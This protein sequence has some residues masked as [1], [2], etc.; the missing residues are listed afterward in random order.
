MQPYFKLKNYLV[1]MEWF[2]YLFT[3]LISSG[4]LLLKSLDNS[5]CIYGSPDSCKKEINACKREIQPDRWYMRIFFLFT[6]DNLKFWNY[7]SATSF[8]A[9]QLGNVLRAVPNCVVCRECSSEKKMDYLRA[10]DFLFQHCM[11]CTC[12]HRSRKL[13]IVFRYR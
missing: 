2:F 5:L 10:A 7:K 3:Y 1:V 4:C 6:Q 12:W 9:W 11:N 13:S 8:T